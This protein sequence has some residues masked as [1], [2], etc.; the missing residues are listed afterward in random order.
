MKSSPRQATLRTIVY[1]ILTTHNVNK[2]ITF[3]KMKS[4]LHFDFAIYVV[5]TEQVRIGILRDKRGAQCFEVV[6]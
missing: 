3:G 6:R 1:D 2:N 5:H 4:P